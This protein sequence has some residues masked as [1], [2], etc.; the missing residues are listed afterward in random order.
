[1]PFSEGVNGGSATPAGWTLQNPDNGTTWSAV[2]VTNGAG[3][4]SSNVWTFDNFN[5]NAIG[6]EDRLLTPMIAAA[7]SFCL[8]QPSA[9]PMRL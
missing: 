3:C 5:Y 2:S 4:A 9:K 7:S 6:Q 8:M 1:M